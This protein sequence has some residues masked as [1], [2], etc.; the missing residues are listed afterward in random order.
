MAL[1]PGTY[2]RLRREAAGVT[3][4]AVAIALAAGQT[5]LQDA[6]LLRVEQIEADLV[7]ATAREIPLMRAVFRFDSQVLDQLADIHFFRAD[8][9]HPR[10][11][12]VCGCSELDACLDHRRSTA[13]HWIDLDLCSGCVTQSR[14]AAA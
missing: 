1:S 9:P 3:R 7:F 10:L 4:E 11:C 2:L 6:A 12:R 14:S 13:C 8:L 5:R